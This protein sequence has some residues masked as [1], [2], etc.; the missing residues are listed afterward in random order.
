MG[1]IRNVVISVLMLAAASCATTQSAALETSNF[2]AALQQPGVVSLPYKAQ[3][4]GLVLIENIAIDG[5][6]MSFALDTGA[7]HSAIF[8]GALDK[9]KLGSAARDSARVHGM[10][11]T[12]ERNIVLAR[13]FLIGEQD[14]GNTPLVVLD[15]RDLGVLSWQ[16]YDGII[17]MDI[18]RNYKLYFSKPTAQ[19]KL[20][21]AGLEVPIPNRWQRVKLSDVSYAEGSKA[22]HTLDIDLEGKPVPALLDTGAEFSVLNWKAVKSA[23]LKAIRRALKKDWQ[24][25]GAIGTF[26]PVSKA[27]IDGLRSGEKRWDDMEFVIMSLND[28]QILGALERPFAIAGMNLLWNETLLIDFEQNYM[29]LAPR[30][31]KSR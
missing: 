14:F 6:P 30:G 2:E 3:K 26:S 1:H 13:S 25:Q 31:A 21:P 9:T 5:T 7:T 16:D 23:E 19:L 20:I 29:A 22:L 12:D 8:Q 4:H 15:D 24:A 18:L 11:D 17:G 10:I 27:N 28:I